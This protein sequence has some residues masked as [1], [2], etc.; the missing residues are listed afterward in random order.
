MATIPAA[1]HISDSL[2]T[3][4]EVKA[5]LES[6]I[7]SLRQVPGAASVELAATIAGGSITPAGAGGIIVVDTESAAAA[8]DLT[9]IVQ[10]NYPDNA[11]ILLRNANAARVVTLKHAATG[12]GQMFLSRSADAVLDDTKR[13]VLLQRR[14]TDWHEV[15]RSPAPL[16]MP[17]VTKS[18]GF[19]IGPEHHGSIILCTA[20]FTVTV[21]AATT[22]GNGFSVGIFNGNTLD[23]TVTIDFA[24]SEALNQITNAPIVNA[25]QGVTLVT[26]GTDWYHLGGE[27]RRRMAAT[28]FGATVFIAPLLSEYWEVSALTGNVTTLDMNNPFTGSHVRIRFV[29]DGTGGRTVAVPS[30]AKVS[31][32]L[33]STANQ[34]S[35]LDLTFSAAELRW[36]GFWT[37]IPV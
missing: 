8:D 10:T 2:R 25:R 23:N 36:E 26:N 32:S 19:T 20:S 14:G 3:E 21:P 4:G 6:V 5:D 34:A 15:D 29:Q 16:Q 11:C 1:G 17:V 7:A 28:N 22:L 27:F 9:T 31:G 37:Q 24:G 33:A 12:S 30:G 13:W 35:V 18:S